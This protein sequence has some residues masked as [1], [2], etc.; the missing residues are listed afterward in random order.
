MSRRLCDSVVWIEAL[1]VNAYLFEHDGTLTLIDTGTPL[2]AA[3]IRRSIREAGFKSE[4]IDR[5]LLTHYDIDHVGSVAKLPTDAPIY[6]GRG[7]LGLLSGT[8][9]P[10]WGSI[11]GLS[12]RFSGPFIPD[13]PRDRIV[14][15]DDGASIGG[16]NVYHTPGHTPGHTVYV[17][18]ERS[19]AFL[20][21][22]VF[23][24]DGSMHPP[25][26]FLC[27]DSTETQASIR[28]FYTRVEHFEVGAMGH[29]TP[30]LSGGKERLSA[31]V[32]SL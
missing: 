18:P 5:I 4:K 16:F 22:L 17:H 25:P 6:I 27:A 24:R 29:G 30:F 2:D 20:G 11:K 21:D 26:W 3:R 12:H 1:G 28:D 7:D 23:E 32:D 9:R 19:A 13:V 14:P 31:L 8:K 10:S 15:V